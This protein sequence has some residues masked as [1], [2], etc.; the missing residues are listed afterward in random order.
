MFFHR[1]NDRHSLRQLTADDTKELFSVIDANR[2][3]LRR[4][5]PWLDRT[6]SV[7]DTRQFIGAT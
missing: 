6:R 4:W 5:L 7:E 3:Y 2:A 1:L